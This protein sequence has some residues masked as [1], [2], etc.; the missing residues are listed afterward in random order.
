MDLFTIILLGCGL[1][2]DCFAVSVTRGICA[3]QLKVRP[4]LKMALLFGFFQAIMPTIGFGMGQAFAKQIKFVD[5]WIA[6]G[7]LFIIGAKMIYESIKENRKDEEEK[8]VCN[9]DLF[10]F[11]SLL[12]LAVAT[13]ID[14][15]A[16]GLIF[17]SYPQKLFISVLIIG[18]ISFGA[19][20]I[21]VKFGHQF[22]KKININ[23]EI[24]GGVVL[25]FIGIKILVE[26]L[27]LS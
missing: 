9:S 24:V 19:S 26:H 14:A 2:M 8:T 21:G 17:I 4:A 7:V 15:L 18:F 12:V 3:D 11:S 1:A 25:I 20:M 27:Y 16:T 5:H 23:V 22:G 10:K 13:S 6:F